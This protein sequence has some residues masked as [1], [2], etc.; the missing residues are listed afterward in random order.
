MSTVA[1]EKQ[2]QSVK[3]RKTAAQQNFVLRCMVYPTKPGEFTAECVDLDIMVRSSSPQKAFEEL[4][5]A[6]KGY[7]LVVLAGDNEGLLPRPSPLSHRIH[8]HLLVLRAALTIGIRRTFLVSD[9]TM[10]LC[11]C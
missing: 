1:D 10:D 8:Y 6:V 2:V 5:E 9:M 7:V 11:S 3:Q 4:R